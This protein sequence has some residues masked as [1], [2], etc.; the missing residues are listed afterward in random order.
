M[1]R[2]LTSAVHAALETVRAGFMKYELCERV[3][4][5]PQVRSLKNIVPPP[6]KKLFQTGEEKSTRNRPTV[7]PSPQLAGMIRSW[8]NVNL[9]PESRLMSIAS[10]LIPIPK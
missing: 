6:P 9:Q 10:S 3:A 5:E 1:R 8:M 4:S 7:P 2:N